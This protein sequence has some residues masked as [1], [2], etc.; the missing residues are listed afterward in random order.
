HSVRLRE[1]GNGATKLG[2]LTLLLIYARILTPTHLAQFD[3]GL[4]GFEQRLATH[5]VSADALGVASLMALDGGRLAEARVWSERALEANPDQIEALVSRGSLA[6]GDQQT[7]IARA[8]FERAL[9]VNALD[10]RSWSG[11]A[12][13]NMLEQR[14]DLALEAFQRAVANMTGHIGTWIGLGWCQFLRRDVSAAR[15]AFERALHLDRNFA[16]SHGALA[17]ALAAQGLRAEAEIEIDIALRLDRTSLSA[18]YA[19]GILSGEVDDPQAFLRLAQRVLSQHRG[20]RGGGEG[21]SLADLVLG[22][23]Q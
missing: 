20:P 22:R 2:P 14:L 9:T 13:A 16:E 4:R 15:D 10:G 6:L 19:Q 11:L 23:R 21:A 5:L 18:R 8:S 12:F 3:D 17:V 7:R 1:G